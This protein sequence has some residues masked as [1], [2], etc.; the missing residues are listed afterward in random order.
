[1]SES[2]QSSPQQCNLESSLSQLSIHSNQSGANANA[3][4]NV[5]EWDQSILVD[6]V[7]G[8]GPST[9][10]NGHQTSSS[11]A[12]STTTPAAGGK[13]EKDMDMDKMG[14]RGKKS[15]SEMLKRHIEKG[16]SLNLSD[17]DEENLSEELGKWVSCGF[18]L[19]YLSF[20]PMLWV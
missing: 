11:D 3:N 20:L 9:P 6:T 12:E 14:T 8:A 15:L 13:K 5:E 4:A 16:R 19:P 2:T 10:P 18:P 17:E 1:M 7:T